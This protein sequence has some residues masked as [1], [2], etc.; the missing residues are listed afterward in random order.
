MLKNYLKTTLRLFRRHR[1]YAVITVGGLA[2]AMAVCILTITWAQYEFSFDRFHKNGRDIFRFIAEEKREQVYRYDGAPVPLGPVIEK[3]LPEVLQAVRLS[4]YPNNR[5]E[6]PKTVSFKNRTILAD[7]SF[8]S[9]FSFPLVQGDPRTALLDAQSVVVTESAA[10]QFFGAADPIGQTLHFLDKK[11]PMKITGVMK[12]MPRTSLLQCDFVGPIRVIDVWYSEYK[13]L[14]I[15]DEW[16]YASY[17]L[18]ARLAPDADPKAVE[19]K[20]AAIVKERNPKADYK[21]SLQPLFQAHL[22]SSGFTRMGLSNTTP[23]DISQVRIFLLISFVVLLMAAINYTNLA[24]A[25]SLKR[26]REIGVRK[27]NGA[28]RGDIAR[29]FLGE[30]LLLAFVAL[31]GALL[32]VALLLPMFK[33]IFGREMDIA[34]VP[35]IPLALSLISLTLFAGLVSGIYPAF[36]V[37]SFTP[38]KALKEKFRPA[39][40]SFINLRRGLVAT[41]IIGSATLIVVTAVFLLQIRFIETKDLGYDR[42]NI[43]VTRFPDGEHL[44][45]FK[46]DISRHPGVL[47]VADGLEPTL[48]AQGHRMDG[49]RFSWE[50]KS[51]EANVP[52]DFIFVDED[53]LKTYKMTM[54][55]GRFFSKDFPSDN[56]NYVLNEAAVRAMGLTDPIG[57]TFKLRKDSGRI[58]GVIKDFHLGTL[59]AKIGP[60]IF[61]YSPFQNLAIRLDPRQTQDVIR[62]IATTWKSY[63]K[64][65]PFEYSFLEDRLSRMYETDRNAARIILLFGLLSLTISCLGLFGLI[66]FMA[67][68]K[69][70][71][72]GIR[73]VLGATVPAILKFMSREFAT[74]VGLAIVLAFPIAFMISSSWLGNFAYRID[75]AWWIFAGSGAV[76]FAI[77][78]LTM[79]WRSL[80]AATANPVDSLRYE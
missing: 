32:L 20:V 77:T 38:V 80:R 42:K 40:S 74:L 12:D 3:T 72:I 69:T 68:Q 24:T 17:S 44:G 4:M 52:M 5:I 71:E 19:A 14:K 54:A 35:K 39:R 18:Y 16:A 15:W 53:Y 21:L 79:T 43:L 61:L 22:Q 57:K 1:G 76:V 37:S 47:S 73:K 7:P 23:L 55:E 78:L 25:Q 60:A 48:G 51:P 36:F 49:N 45:A 2:L 62:F 11:V 29:Q 64:E 6:S 70:K 33:S 41:Q 34:L 67:E 63:I 59:R 31:I 65:I 58:I 50:G 13:G 26:S 28:S 46:D 66:S 9:L 75:L 56:K 8:F 27:V 10:R 30:S